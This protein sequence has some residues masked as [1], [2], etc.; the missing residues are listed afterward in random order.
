MERL[1]ENTTIITTTFCIESDLYNGF[2]IDIVNND[3]VTYDA[4]LYHKNYGIKDHL[5][6]LMC[7]DI[8]YDDF[9]EN[10]ARNVADYIPGYIND[11]IDN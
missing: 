1:N 5:Y 9:I 8:S 6:G 7:K 10:V 11:Y 4:Y 2:M 3:G